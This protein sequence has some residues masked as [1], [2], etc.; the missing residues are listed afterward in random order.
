MALLRIMMMSAFN[1]SRSRAVSLR[2]SPFFNDDA[3]AL[4][5]EAVKAWVGP[6]RCAVIATHGA[7]RVKAFAD[8]GVI[9]RDGRVVVAGSY[10]NPASATAR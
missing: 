8:A 9:L 10:R 6:G 1:A 7:K 4:I 5:S 3:S 2:V